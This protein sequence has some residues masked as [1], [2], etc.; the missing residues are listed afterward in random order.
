M[1]V[2]RLNIGD[3][4]FLEYYVHRAALSHTSVL[5]REEG[6]H[7]AVW[8][9]DERLIYF[10]MGSIVFPVRVCKA[11]T[12]QHLLLSHS[13]LADTPYAHTQLDTSRRRATF[14]YVIVRLA[15]RIEASRCKG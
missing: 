5:A 1:F 10:S 15:H 2:F 11:T 14:H 13:N 4:G 9:P 6:I 12:R 8:E 3:P 7:S